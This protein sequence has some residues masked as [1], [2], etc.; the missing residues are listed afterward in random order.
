[1]L[2]AILT[3]DVVLIDKLLNLSYENPLF[4]TKEE[5]LEDLE[6]LNS[7]LKELTSFYFFE[8]SSSKVLYKKILTKEKSLIKV[9]SIDTSCSEDEYGTNFDIG[10]FKIPFEDNDI[11][12][13]IDQNVFQIKDEFKEEYEKAFRKTKDSYSKEWKQYL[14]DDSNRINEEDEINK[15]YSFRYQVFRELIENIDI[16]IIALV[17]H[18]DHRHEEY[19]KAGKTRSYTKRYNKALIVKYSEENAIKY[20]Q[21]FNEARANKEENNLF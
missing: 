5:L 21:L 11:L 9:M 20:T 18:V 10:K 12:A 15:P 19:Y 14:F 17:I 16:K 4:T 8:V 2:Y 3:N 6:Q 13:I 1:M 7:I